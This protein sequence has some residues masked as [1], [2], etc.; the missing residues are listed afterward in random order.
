MNVKLFH[1][2]FSSWSNN[3]LWYCLQLIIKTHVPG[4]TQFFTSNKQPGNIMKVQCK[5]PTI[6]L[7]VPNCSPRMKTNC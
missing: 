6:L 5:C 3:D 7:L 4:S 2:V 1:T